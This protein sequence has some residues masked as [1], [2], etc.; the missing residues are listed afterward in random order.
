M[1][2]ITIRETER[3]QL[4]EFLPEIID[5]YEDRGLDDTDLIDRFESL[6]ETFED[7]PDE[8]RA[9]YE[10]SDDTWEDLS[11]ALG[12]LDGTRPAWLRA[13]I[14]RRAE[15]PPI[16]MSFGTMLPVGTILTEKNPVRPD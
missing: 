11:L 14:A 3:S 4:V 10:A 13:K 5:L 7:E 6:Q 16:H 1:R 15:L 12:E 2:A 9:E 8:Y